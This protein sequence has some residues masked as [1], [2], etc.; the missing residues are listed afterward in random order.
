MNAAIGQDQRN[1]DRVL[2]FVDVAHGVEDVYV[3]GRN[4]EVKF[5]VLL[6]CGALGDAYPTCDAWL[7]I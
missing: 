1:L 5:G 3:R 6:M 7:M 2:M 4:L